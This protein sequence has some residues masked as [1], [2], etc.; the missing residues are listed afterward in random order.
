MHVADLI[1]L[2]LRTA[3]TLLSSPLSGMVAQGFGREVLFRGFEV[4]LIK[5]R[6]RLA[7]G[8]SVAAMAVFTQGCCSKMRFSV[9]GGEWRLRLRGQ[10]R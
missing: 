7:K 2:R 1:A 10:D 3:L 8:G 6:Y 4:M 9:E 5:V